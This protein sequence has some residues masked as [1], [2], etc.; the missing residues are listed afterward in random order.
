MSDGENK[1][2]KELDRA[3]GNKWHA[4]RIESRAF[5]PGYPDV[6]FAINHCLSGHIELKFGMST[7]M[8]KI[9]ASQIRW[10]T[11][12]VKMGGVVFIASKIHHKRKWL[13][14]LHR[15]N[16]IKELHADRKLSIWDEIRIN[17]D[18]TLDGLT[19]AIHHYSH[20]PEDYYDA[21]Y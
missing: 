10:I 17:P 9:R 3:M 16:Q 6:S 8:P 13:F 1:F 2:W 21:V 19:S 14:L 15:G 12:R 18:K 11:N 7:S 20:Y 5:T 4:S